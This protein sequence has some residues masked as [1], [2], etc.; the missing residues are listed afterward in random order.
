MSSK[1]YFRHDSFRKGQKEIIKDIYETILLKKNILLHAPTGTGKTDSAL[2]A[3]I[4]FALEKN[5]KILFLTP[6]ISQHK[7]A[8]EVIEDLND[9][10]NLN[11]KAIDFVGKKNMCIEPVI[12]KT[13]SGF[14]EICLMACKKKQCPFFEN[15]RTNNKT[16]KEILNYILEKK[17]NE[18]KTLSHLEIKKIAE[19]LTDLSGNRYPVCAYELAKMYAKQCKVIIADYYHVFSS[20]IMEATL[21]EVGINL[22]D[23]IIIVDEAHNLEERLLKLMSRSLN[24]NL[25]HR[26]ITEAKAIKNAKLKYLLEK[27][28]K[29]V[30]DVSAKQL[31][32]I[33]EKKIEKKEILPKEI[34]ENGIEIIEEIK[35]AGAYFVEK[36]EENSS[37]LISISLFLEE[38]LK[39]K[40]AH[41]R[42]IKKERNSVSVKHNALDIMPLTKTVFDNCYASIIMSAT[43]TPLL[44]YTNIF[45]L[46]NVVTK[47]YPSPF[48]KNKRLNLL[49][50]DVSTKFTNRNVT[51]Y[52]KIAEYVRD[53]VNAI[54]GNCVVFF[55]SF[56]VM[57]DIIPLLNIINKPR[58]VQEEKMNSV[59][60]EKMIFDFKKQATKFGCVLFAVMGGKASEG[61]DLP[62][63]LLLGA[64]V[65]GIPLVKLELETQAKIE[66]YEQKFKNGWNYAYIQPAIQKV[67]QSAGRVI[68]TDTDKG[69]VVYLDS[70]FY[71]DNYRRCFSKDMQF[72]LCREPRVLIERFFKK[73]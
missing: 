14:Y 39:E 11:I 60:F 37:A 36:L 12:S 34:E 21:R 18:K 5:L 57:N 13:E 52:K 69:V 68:R 33:K 32:K 3:A 64:V 7:I 49:V 50:T 51:E 67:I 55:P 6:K 10:Y 42:F 20:R 56:E 25:L 4:T 72:A 66:Y 53:S 17:L 26:G 28:L 23:C 73:E 27:Q 38:W 35:E 41:I 54:P 1:I 15:I 40:A 19:E 62:G 2:S 65:V 45:G 43:L 24:T 22:E 46:T 59:D 9:K 47:E 48:D 30:E 63:E 71:W 31:E 16:Q 61:I 29:L 8:L 58:I 70:R 44:M